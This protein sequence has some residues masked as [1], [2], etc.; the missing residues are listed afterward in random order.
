MKVLLLIA[1]SIRSRHDI[2]NSSNNCIKSSMYFIQLYHISLLLEDSFSLFPE[3]ILTIN[4][5][6][7][8]LGIIYAVIF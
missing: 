6:I 1:N 3:L 2:V 4:T 5:F 7:E 8:K